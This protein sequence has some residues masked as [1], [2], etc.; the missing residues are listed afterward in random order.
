MPTVEPAPVL[1]WELPLPVLSPASTTG[2]TNS[3]L[4][5]INKREISSLYGLRG[6]AA[7]TVVFD[8]YSVETPA[9][10]HFPG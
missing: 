7:L 8:H 3:F 10:R 4:T 5:N 9:V 6:I 1:T 2:K